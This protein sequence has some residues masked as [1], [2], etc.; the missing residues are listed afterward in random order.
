MNVNFK[1][2]INQGKSFYFTK[3]NDNKKTLLKNIPPPPPPVFNPLTTSVNGPTSF[4]GSLGNSNALNQA[5][6]ENELPSFER[7]VYYRHP[8]C[9]D[10]VTLYYDILLSKFIFKDASIIYTKDGSAIITS[11]NWTRVSDNAIINLTSNGP[12]VTILAPNV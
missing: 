6:Y 9:G 2:S 5:Q 11:D 10:C 4:V 3:S 8:G 7:V 1:S 12:V